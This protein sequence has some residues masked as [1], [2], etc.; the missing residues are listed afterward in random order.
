MEGVEVR[1]AG[2]GAVGGQDLAIELDGEFLIGGVD[3]EGC[4][5]EGAS[6]RASEGDGK[7]MHGWKMAVG[8]ELGDGKLWNNPEG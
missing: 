1:D 6:E 4:G 7:E 5:V 2:V 3:G 8:G